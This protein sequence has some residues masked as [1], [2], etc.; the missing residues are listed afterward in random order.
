MDYNH[1]ARIL[2]VLGAIL[3]FAG[4]GFY[5]LSRLN[6][7]SGKIPGDLILIRENYTCLVPLTSSL[8]ISILLTILINLIVLFLKK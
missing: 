8:I 2:L 5:L 7:P 6:I 1:I 4:A 3:L